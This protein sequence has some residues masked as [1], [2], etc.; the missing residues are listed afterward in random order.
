MSF[1]TTRSA[2]VKNGAMIVAGDVGLGGGDAGL[3]C[4]DGGLRLYALYGGQGGTGLDAVAFFYVEVVMRP[5]A[6]A[7]MLT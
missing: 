6:V 3:L 5:K 2:A 4:G 1:F 7:P